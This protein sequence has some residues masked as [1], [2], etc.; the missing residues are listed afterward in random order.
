VTASAGTLRRP[1]RQA[2]R[3]IRKAATPTHDDIATTAEW[4]LTVRCTNPACGRLIAFQKTLFPGG[5][6]D[7][8]LKVAGEPSV[9]CPH[10]KTLVRVRAEQIERRQV[11]LTQ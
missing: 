8:R 9:D 11:V 3:A 1:R 6:P 5:H 4:Y 2:E 10:C 7:L